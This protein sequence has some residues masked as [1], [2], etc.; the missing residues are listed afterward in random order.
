MLAEGLG[1]YL[2][3][4]RGTI[5]DSVFRS[6]PRGALGTICGSGILNRGWLH[7]GQ[8]PYFLYYLSGYTPLIFN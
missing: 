6:I 3:V 1:T 7:A 2:A 5:L 8:V 4:L